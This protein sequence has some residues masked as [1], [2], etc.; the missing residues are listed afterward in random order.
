MKH[1]NFALGLKT[2]ALLAFVAAS[3]VAIVQP[4][5]PVTSDM[6]LASTTAMHGSPVGFAH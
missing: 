6:A 1:L 2:L 4:A 3:T 5:A